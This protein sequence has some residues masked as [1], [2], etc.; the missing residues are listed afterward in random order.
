MKRDAIKQLI[1]WKNSKR[2]KPLILKGAR[3]VGKTWLMQEFGRQEY[4][5]T[6]YVT[7]DRNKNLQNA[8]K[9]YTNTK[10]LITKL[11][12]ET[13]MKITPEDTLV[14]LDEIQEC[15]DAI[16]SLKYFNEK[17]PELHIIV[18]GS[19]LGLAHHNGTGF[20]VGKV[21]FMTLYP[22]SFLEFL[23]ANGEELLREAMEAGKIDTV[24][25]FASKL[26]NYLKYYY[27]VGGMPEVVQ[28]FINNRD[29][30][31]VRTI[32]EEIIASYNE[33]FSK[34]TD[35]NTAERISMVWNSISSQLAKENKKFI[36]NAIKTG[37]RAKDFEIALA[38]LRDSGLVYKVTRISKPNLPIKAYEDIDIFKLYIVDV[39]LLGALSNLSAKAILEENRIFTEFKGALTE[40][41]VLQ[42]LK[43]NQNDIHYWTSKSN[44]A[45]VDFITQVEDYVIPIEVKATVNLKAKSLQQYR[46][47]YNPEKS[48]RTSLADFEINNGLYNIPLYLIG[49]MNNLIELK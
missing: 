33:D 45:E 8:F 4:K 18:A 39:G 13:Q 2:R 30:K 19:L 9:D 27:F 7:F 32:Q 43:I 34:H 35:S 44:V 21:N 36:Y 28:S 29:F 11:E 47:D 23:S 24:K 12:I 38:W 17:A 48:I 46:K 5:K 49:L 6:A 1:E 20:P 26:I 22:L 16:T 25:T 15:P 40:Q 3:Q 42:Q 14:I 10:E 31:E 41:Y 37:A